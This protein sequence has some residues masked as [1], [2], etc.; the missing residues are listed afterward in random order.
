[1]VRSRS[2]AVAQTTLSAGAVQHRRQ[3]A[4]GGSP[5]LAAIDGIHVTGS[6]PDVRPWLH[7]AA[8][9][10]VPLQDRARSAE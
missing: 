9:I 3:V 7:Q 10:V 6:V 5:A 8:C 1:M 2:L 4:G